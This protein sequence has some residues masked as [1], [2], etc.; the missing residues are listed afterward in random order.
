MAFTEPSRRL[1]WWLRLS[2]W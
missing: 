2:L 1:P